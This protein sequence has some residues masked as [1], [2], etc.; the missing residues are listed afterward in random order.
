MHRKLNWTNRNAMLTQQFMRGVRD[1]KITSRLAPMRPREMPFRELQ[2]ELRQI[3]REKRA[4]SSLPTVPKAQAQPHQAKPYRPDPPKPTNKSTSP[5][6]SQPTT[7]TPN[8][9]ILMDLLHTVQQLSQKVEQLSNQ[10]SRPYSPKQNPQTSAPGLTTNTAAPRVFVCHRCGQEGH[11]ARGCR[12]LPL[13]YQGQRLEGKP[14]EARE[15][16]QPQQ[17]QQQQ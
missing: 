8:D 7:S 10:H 4:S 9:G 5:P 14:S 12:S 15:N 1:D 3:E 2:A 13:N 16:A 6:T 17:Q 11:I